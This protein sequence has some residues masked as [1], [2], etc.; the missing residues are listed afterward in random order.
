[1]IAKR[2]QGVLGPTELDHEPAGQAVILYELKGLDRVSARQHDDRPAPR[3][4]HPSQDDRCQQG[5]RENHARRQWRRVSFV[6]RSVPQPHSQLAPS[7]RSPPCRRDDEEGHVT[8]MAARLPK[9]SSQDS[10]FDPI[11]PSPSGDVSRHSSG[12]K[13]PE[14]RPDFTPQLRRQPF[15]DLWARFRKRFPHPSMQFP[16]VGIDQRRSNT[17]SE[18][19]HESQGRSDGRS[20]IFGEQLKGA[21]RKVNSGDGQPGCECPVDIGPNG[22]K[23]R[24]CEKVAVARALRRRDRTGCRSAKRPIQ[25][26]QLQ[27]Q[28]YEA[29]DLRPQL[30][31]EHQVVANRH[32][33][34][35][36]C[37]R[38]EAGSTDSVK[39]GCKQEQAEQ[40]LPDQQ[41]GSSPR[42]PSA[43]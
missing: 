6:R 16:A 5:S 13:D 32:H 19:G 12:S 22:K 7:I 35:R 37:Q 3:Q 8:V 11:D 14:R 21:A 17:K 1:M 25:Q 15:E 26:P 33:Q 29:E 43:C 4:R 23:G 30:P 34:R 2:R 42:Q 27:R 36:G 31:K 24:Q 41:T 38:T 28:E 18:Y 40:A 39:Q 9:Q 10:C 20:T